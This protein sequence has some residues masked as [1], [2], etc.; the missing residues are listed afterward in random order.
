VA[1]DPPVFGPDRKVRWFQVIEAE[2]IR[3]FL[4]SVSA[5][6][7]AACKVLEDEPLRQVSQGR[8]TRSQLRLLEHVAAAEGKSIGDVAAFLGVSNPAASK[9]VEKLVRRQLL[10]RSDAKSDR[11]ASQL[12]LT[13][14]SRRLLA[15]LEEART[16]RITEIFLP[17]STEELCR[18]AE[19]LRNLANIVTSYN[20]ELQPR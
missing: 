13:E 9:A 11:R 5:F 12:T 10:R 6:A 4:G 8:L 19:F 3:E 17:L 20:A 2:R 7:V 14:A 16:Q 15:S 18:T 1:F